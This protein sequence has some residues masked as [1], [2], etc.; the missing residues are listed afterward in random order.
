MKEQIK[1]NVKNMTCKTRLLREINTVLL[2]LIKTVRASTLN[3]Y[4]IK[5]DEKTNKYISE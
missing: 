1:E 2:I 5:L 3:N 4:N